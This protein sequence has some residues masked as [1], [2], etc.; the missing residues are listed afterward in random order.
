MLLAR[1]PQLTPAGCSGCP[2][3]VVCLKGGGG[4][5]LAQPAQRLN[6]VVTC[7]VRHA[8]KPAMLTYLVVVAVIGCRV[9][10]ACR[11]GSGL[12]GRCR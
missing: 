4:A 6:K 12:Q 7:Q 2:A 1:L 8:H 3:V 11:V 9:Q 10:G 5:M